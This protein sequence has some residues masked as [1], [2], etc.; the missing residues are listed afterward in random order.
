MIIPHPCIRVQQSCHVTYIAQ[1]ANN[2]R[3]FLLR[4]LKH[5][6]PS[7]KIKSYE[8]YVCPIL[9][10]C[11][12]GWTSH[13]SQDNYKLESVQCHM[14]RFVLN[15]FLYTSSVNHM[16]ESLHWT[17]LA[18]CHTQTKLYIITPCKIINDIL[19]IPTHN[20]LMQSIPPHPI[21]SHCT[22]HFKVRD[23]KHTNCHFSL[24]YIQYSAMDIA[25]SP[26]I[27]I[28]E[29]RLNHHL[30]SLYNRSTVKNYYNKYMILTLSLYI[31]NK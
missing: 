22:H 26:D 31:I 25:L 16:L 9:E 14:A 4:N 2:D 24:I 11:S 12:T 1:K 7:V 6:L 21:Y 3:A 17:T 23:Y 29:D 28:F 19:H 15:D 18:Q 8:L 20:I 10:Y 30:Q 13:T 5:C 27:E